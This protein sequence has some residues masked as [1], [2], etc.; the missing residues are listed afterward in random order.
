MLCIILVYNDLNT[1]I[2][3]TMCAHDYN[4]NNSKSHNVTTYI[5]IL[6]YIQILNTTTCN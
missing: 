1:N 2:R 4:E 6:Q 5:H 3:I